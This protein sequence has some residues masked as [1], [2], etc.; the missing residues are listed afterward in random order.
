MAAAEAAAAFRALQGLAPL[1][2]AV[3]TLRQ[4][5]QPSATYIQ[6]LVHS[7]ILLST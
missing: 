5:S 6:V 3:L 1:F 7:N 4:R 2:A